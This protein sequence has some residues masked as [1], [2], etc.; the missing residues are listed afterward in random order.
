MARRLSRQD[1]IVMIARMHYEDRLP[2]NEV[3]ARLGVSN[4]TVSRALKKALELGFVEIR[5]VPHALR[6][7]ELEEQLEDRYGLQDAIV[8]E[9]RTTAEETLRVLGG[10]VAHFVESRLSDGMNIGI[11]D[12]RSVASVANGLRTAAYKKIN[13]FPLIGGVGV[14]QLPTHPSEICRVMALHLGGDAWN[15]PVPAMADD[16]ASAKVLRQTSSIR[17]IF[18][19]MQ[20][21]DMAIVGLGA[22]D[23]E[24][25]IFRHGVITLEQMRSAT[26][27]GAV[28]TICARF[29]DARGQIIYTELE[30]QT[31]A[32]HL[33]ELMQCPRRVLVANGAVKVPAIRGA[34]LGGIVNALGTDAQT[35][36]SLLE[37]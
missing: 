14:R 32:I 31:I 5:V 34:L 30:D 33:D 13:V 21:L 16:P 18:E 2:Q 10:A 12:G 6:A 1:E 8:V 26:A 29:F 20:K 23:D 19:M 17:P 3:A 35:A 22:L 36:Q 24:A 11:S 9:M 15:L 28:G 37:A 27:N 25:P 7:R 4:S